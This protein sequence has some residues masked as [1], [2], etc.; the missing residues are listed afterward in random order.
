MASAAFLIVLGIPFFQIEF[1]S[2]DAQ[3]LP[4][5][6]SA[7]QVDDVLRAD[8]PPF[9]DSPMQL[10]VAGD[11]A[12]AERVAAEAAELPGVAAVNEPVRPGERHQCDRGDL[13]EADR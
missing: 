9:R 2:V 3:V 1:T 13:V 8:F 7:H 11:A 5:S 12:E 6:A 10:A 4:E